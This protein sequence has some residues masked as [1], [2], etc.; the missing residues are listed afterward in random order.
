MNIPFKQIAVDGGY[1]FGLTH[2]GAVWRLY[3]AD[4][5]RTW[6]KIDGPEIVVPPTI[7]DPDYCGVCGGHG[8]IAKIGREYAC[9]TCNGT[10]RHG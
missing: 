7:N 3:A 9:A 8:H 5:T 10:G 4:D 2:D 6:K 1:V